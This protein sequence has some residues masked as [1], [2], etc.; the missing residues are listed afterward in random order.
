MG[1]LHTIKEVRDTYDF[2]LYNEYTGEK[3]VLTVDPD[4][5]QLFEDKSIFLELPEACPFLRYDSKGKAYYTVHLTRPD[6]CRE[7]RCWNLLVINSRG[8][9]VGRIIHH[10][11]CTDDEV[12]KQIWEQCIKNFKGLD[13]IRWE[14]EVRSILASVG[15]TVRA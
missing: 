13:D 2:L 8:R 15:Y 4:K 5:I 11:L 10:T 3:T 9:R 7:F 6:I 14:M 1:L 12:L